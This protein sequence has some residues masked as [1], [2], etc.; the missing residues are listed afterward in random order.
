MEKA[1]KSF[2]VSI[3]LFVFTILFL[4][5]NRAYSNQINNTSILVPAAYATIQEAIDAASDGDEI[6]VSPGTYLENI[7]F[8]GKNIILRSTD[9][10]NANIRKSTVIDG[11][12]TDST[13][14]FSG[15]EGS[16]CVLSGFYITNGNARA[17]GGICGND[18]NATISYNTLSGNKARYYG[19][20]VYRCNGLIQYN[21]ITGN[22]L[23]IELYTTGGG[24]SHCHGDIRNNII[25]M[26]KANRGGGIHFCNGLIANNRIS[27]NH[28]YQGGA[29]SRCQG[30][31]RN[32][33]ITLN[34]ADS[35][36]GGLYISDGAIIN[37]EIIGNYAKGD[38]GGLYDCNGLIA[39]NNISYNTAGRSG[40]GVYK[41]KGLIVNSIIWG[42]QSE[43]EGRQMS[44]S[45]APFWCCIENWLGAGRNNISSNPRFEDPWNDNYHLADS[46]PCIN[47]GNSFYIYGNNI[48]DLDGEC[49][50]AGASIDI[51]PDEYG[52]A[53]DK[54]GDFLSDPD[55][56][57]NGTDANLGD[58]DGDGLPDGIEIMRGT[59]P[60]LP[61]VATGMKIPEDY[62]EI[63]EAIFKS[64]PGESVTVNKGTY[65]ENLYFMNKNI[66]LQ[67]TNPK[68]VETVESTIID[69][70]ELTSVVFFS[71]NET[72][73]CVMKG[74]TIQNASLG[75]AG[76][77]HGNYTGA[78]IEYNRLINNSSA[79][80]GGGISF[81]NGS[82]H[83]NYF[84]N[85]FSK[86]NG[87]ALYECHGSIMQNSIEF[88]TA[89]F[90]AG[91]ANCDG[92]IKD[93]LIA[94][95]DSSFYGGGFHKCSATI[96]NNTISSNTAE[97]RGGGFYSCSGLITGNIISGNHCITG[98]GG[99]LFFFEGTFR[100]NIVTGNSAFLS[101]GGLYY[102]LGVIRNNIISRNFTIDD[103]SEGGGLYDCHGDIYNNI[104][105]LNT[106]IQSGG[107]LYECS[108]SFIGNMITGNRA[109]YGHGGGFY[110][111]EGPFQ[112]NTIAENFAGWKGGG[113]FH[114]SGPITNCIIWNN[115]A[116]HDGDQMVQCNTPFWSCIQGWG[117]GGCCIVTDDPKFADQS[118]G[119]FHLTENSPCIDAGNTFYLSG[120]YFVDIDKECR[121]SGK[122]V[123][124]GADEFASV[125]D[126]DGDLISDAEESIQG[127][128]PSLRD[129][130]D[131][132]LIDGIE[133]LR[134]TD[135]STWNEPP[136]LSVPND[137]E[138]LQEAVFMAFPE[139][140]I[141]VQPG[142]YF[143]NL[144]MEGKNVI[145]QSS[146]PITPSI[147]ESTVIDGTMIDSVIAF[148]GDEDETCM[149]RGFT[150]THGNSQD[151]SNGG[152]IKCNGA[153]ATIEHNR[154][155]YNDAKYGGGI[156]RCYG[157]IRDNIISNNSAQNGGGGIYS[158]SQGVIKN[159]II[160]GNS[161]GNSGGGLLGCHSKII[162]NEI[163]DNVSVQCGGGLS[164]CCNEIRNNIISGN[165]ANKYGGGIYDCDA[166]IQNNKISDNY[167]DESGGGL[168]TREGIIR[169]NLISGNS[170]KES[171]GG[172]SWFR[173]TFQNNTVT[174]NFAK[175][176]AGLHDC[177][178]F[179]VNSIIWNNTIPYGKNQMEECSSPFW[180]CIENW[181]G[182]GLGNLVDNPEFADPDNGDFQ[183]L[184]T[185]PCI[186]TGN[187]F[188]VFGEFIADMDG[189]CRI[190]GES[191]D[192]GSYEYGSSPDFDGDLLPDAKESFY[193]CH[194][195]I[196]DTDDDGLIDGIEVMRG[197]EPDIEDMPPGITIPDDYPSIQE[198]VFY[199]FQEEN[200]ILQKGE[201]NENI[202]LMGKNVILQSLNPD[203]E[204]ARNSTII[205]G[206]GL[207]SV[208][209]FSGD[210]DPTC[211]LKGL[212]II[213]GSTSGFGGGIAGNETFAAIEKNR[214]MNNNAGLEGGGIFLCY[215]KIQNNIIAS[216]S[217]EKGGGIFDQYAGRIQNN[218][219]WGNS[220]SKTGGGIY[221]LQ[222]RLKNC[223]LWNNSAPDYP[224]LLLSNSPDPQYC[225]IQDWTGDGE[226]NIIKDPLL[227][228]PEKGKF[229]LQPDSPCI[230]A[231]MMIADLQDDLD[232]DPRPHDSISD[233]RG[234]GSDFDIGAD[235]FYF[236]K[237]NI[238]DHI[239]GRYSIPERYFSVS[240]VNRDGMIDAAD[241]VY[242]GILEAK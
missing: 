66:I 36:G 178:G 172:V 19:G 126:S 98:Y 28:A 194:F 59:D 95:N 174:G 92:Y 15:D 143:E 30:I 185:S 107:G 147:V 75:I 124:I 27:Q 235:E 50:I 102:C 218:T 64:F 43:E 203:D 216:N 138:R 88:N 152:G 130:D 157:M 68:E 48:T 234:D 14:I 225:C 184:N 129:S 200:V 162:Q 171:G 38:A 166:V 49:R 4:T 56:T 5:E 22:E 142:T 211:I 54:D 238:R 231:G 73:S 179:I 108:G 122:S 180:C 105:S 16:T 65:Y 121:I 131:D 241:M 11:K 168:Y 183:L 61:T 199:S 99:G 232:G 188:Y 192:I 149:I 80:N 42:N 236:S 40:G 137:C 159:N 224:Q 148:S 217:A 207:H 21:E 128:D 161:T 91:L 32:N 51:G 114:C 222:R 165:Y 215:G 123:D 34:W 176:G 55:E 132:G 190:S 87:G 94:H 115:K 125:P 198:G 117:E 2:L 9:P 196:S 58:T 164:D 230:D 212:T 201:Y 193:S 154:I 170:A 151:N 206:S 160:S 77:I 69:G 195:E 228:D 63:Q 111:C 223:I 52:S 169:N 110:M 3:I 7:D 62:S 156:Y 39:N 29:F 150:I 153:R 72:S 242:F 120:H 145:L 213:N 93:N 79:R 221:S 112:G 209:T 24:V 205:D 103:E 85:N 226:G 134:G 20:G 220:A 35:T 214:I 96:E 233:T 13:V 97:Y 67:S 239:L 81:C 31:I 173:G 141:I 44:E 25:F 136:G 204:E 47:A 139:E 46:S 8:N 191:V 140:K 23:P 158:S 146:D 106:T 240:D 133:V 197:T 177:K 181:Q 17:G 78:T 163:M 109:E 60:A 127:S 219:I 119:D 116:K 18:C 189:N 175:R 33:S 208:V 104:I 45:S 186:N 26:N 41:C 74:F 155:I 182:T 227:V 82:I 113:L 37:N 167:A 89:N 83:N 101:G 90:G 6:I 10:E 187:S 12:E 70:S 202:H 210:E 237:R 1:K 100:D 86:Q 135:P 71:G 144:R 57:I 84:S 118:E 229:H 76:G 53:I